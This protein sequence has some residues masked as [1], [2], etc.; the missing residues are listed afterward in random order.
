MYLNEQKDGNKVV[1]KL[2]GRLDTESSPDFEKRAKGISADIM[3]LTVDVGGLEYVS[4]AGLRI[5]LAVQK[6]MDKRGG[7]MVIINPGEVVKEVFEITG[8]NEV[9]NIVYNE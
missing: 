3:E 7:K 8:F 6:I 2:V 4:S 9:L 1:L 5:L